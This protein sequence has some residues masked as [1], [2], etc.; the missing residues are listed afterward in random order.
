MKHIP[1]LNWRS[2]RGWT[3]GKYCNSMTYMIYN[4]CQ[5]EMGIGS[6]DVSTSKMIVEDQTYGQKFWHVNIRSAAFI[7]HHGKKLTWWI[8]IWRSI[9]T[10]FVY[11]ISNSAVNHF[12]LDSITYFWTDCLMRKWHFIR[13]RVSY[14]VEYSAFRQ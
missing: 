13:R 1:C 3:R 2:R 4:W 12:D 11:S 9:H 14:N 5:K 6:S 7:M 10:L 8:C